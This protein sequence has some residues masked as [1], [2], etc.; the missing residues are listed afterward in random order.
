MWRKARFPTVSRR[1]AEGDRFSAA[2]RPGRSGPARILAAV[3]NPDTDTV[4]STV[5]TTER[6][7]ATPDHTQPYR[8]LGLADDE[9]APPNLVKKAVAA[10][11][12]APRAPQ[13]HGFMYGHGFEDLDGH[14]W[15]PMWMD[16]APARA[17]T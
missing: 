4:T 17:A 11:G 12:K 1:P 16:F 9:F 2:H 15:E 7:G 6:A 5:D 13:D 14:I 10:G 8:E 3:A